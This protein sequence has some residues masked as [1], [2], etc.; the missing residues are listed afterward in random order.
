MPLQCERVVQQ[1]VIKLTSCC[2]T[3]IQPRQVRV[4]HIQYNGIEH[5]TLNIEHCTYSVQWYSFRIPSEPGDPLVLHTSYFVLKPQGQYS[6]SSLSSSALEKF[7]KDATWML[8]D[9]LLH[10]CSLIHAVN[11]IT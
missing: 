9:G 1:L 11:M 8:S 7:A 3:R 5:T 10:E 4:C 6:Y 2:T